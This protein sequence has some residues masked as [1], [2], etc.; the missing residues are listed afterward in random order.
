MFA[1]SI[2]AALILSSS[3]IA[4]ASSSVDP[5]DMAVYLHD[6]YYGDSAIVSG[7]IYSSDGNVQFTNSG[8]NAVTGSIFHKNGTQFTIPDWYKPDFAS[9]VVTL[10][11]TYYDGAIPDYVDFP[12]ISN[13]VD[14]YIPQYDT[15]PLTITENTHFGTLTI[16]QQITADVRNRDIYLVVDHLSCNWGFSITLNGNGRLYLYVKGYD[17]SGPLNISNGNNP[18]STYIFSEV[19]LSHSNLDLY[20]HVFYEGISNLQVLGKVTGSIATDASSVTMSGGTVNINGLVY[21]PNAAAILESSAAINGRL[22]ANSLIQRGMGQINYN[23]AYSTIPLQALQHQVRVRASIPEGGTVSPDSVN[24]NYGQM[25]Q[26]TAVPNP[27]YLFAGFSS[28]NSSMIP[29]SNGRIT[30]TGPVTLTANFEYAGSY[31]QG[32]LGEYYDTSELD[33][34]SAMKMRRIDRNLA[35]NFMYDSPDP[36][37]DPETFSIRWSGFIR[38]PVTGDYLFKTYSDDGVRV[39]VDGKEIINEWGALS[40]AFTVADSTVHLEAGKYYPITVEYQQ[41]PLYAAA[42]LFWQADGVPMGIIPETAFYVPQETSA[43]YTPAKYYNLLGK[44]G[45]G[46]QNTFYTKDESGTRLKEYSE[47]DN[48][49]YSWGLG[50]P[51]DL[52]SDVF[53]GEMEG[54]LEAKYTESTTLVFSV[55]DGIRVWVGDESGAWFNGGAPV[56][57]EWDQHSIDNFEYTFDTEAG[58]KYRIR[59]QYADFGIGA[60]CIMGWRGDALGHGVIPEQYLY[61]Q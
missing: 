28:S 21:A 15:P 33:N 10:P 39:T 49:D 32:L 34:A 61:S 59:I 45:T 51:G 41:L 43:E 38:P 60:T 5:E 4:D 9:R 25:I 17:N 6:G 48:I 58:H 1:F 55:D 19:S 40:L 3:G 8:S 2:A 46:L 13:Y 11:E 30:V 42:F 29:D 35:F 18:D 47:T 7:D 31:A 24:A 36:V 12:E 26:I 16:G 50:A 57:D 27:G 23:A 37:M 52:D 14:Q 44:A 22:V 56:I 54:Y 20:A 53:Y